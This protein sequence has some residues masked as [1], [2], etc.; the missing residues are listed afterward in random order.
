MYMQQLKN[1][2]RSSWL[3]GLDQFSDIEMKT[4]L[5]I[6]PPGGLSVDQRYEQSKVLLACFREL[7]SLGKTEESEKCHNYSNEHNKA[8]YI[9]QLEFLRENDKLEEYMKS[10][11]E[12]AN[13]DRNDW[14][15]GFQLIS[16]LELKAKL[17]KESPKDLTS[18][19]QIDLQVSSIESFL[20]HDMIDDAEQCLN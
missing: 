9:A 15:K 16:N 7:T 11:K 14:L 1:F 17:A 12:E 19:Q 20:K 2:E 6:N 5:A 4:R 13:S 3:T 18:K 8:S 10:L